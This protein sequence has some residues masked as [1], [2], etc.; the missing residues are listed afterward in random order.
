M[1]KILTPGVLFLTRLKFSWKLLFVC[2]LLT[3]PLIVALGYLWHS[4]R[5]QV[6]AT[7]TELS[8]LRYVKPVLH[9]VR[10]IQERRGRMLIDGHSSPELENQ[11]QQ[12][13]ES[14]QQN[15]S[16][17]PQA[18][19]INQEF[20]ALIEAHSALRSIKEDSPPD[21]I[22]RLHSQLV[23]SALSL[24]YRA[25]D[26]SR[27]MIDP[28][29]ETH[30]LIDLGIVHG[31]LQLENMAQLR[32]IGARALRTHTLD[33]QTLV[34]LREA[35]AAAPV[36]DRYV[37]SAFAGLTSGNAALR[38]QL[39]MAEADIATEK[40]ME[41]VS[42]Q[43][44]GAEISGSAD[45]YWKAATSAIDNVT[46]MNSKIMDKLGNAL[47][48]RIIRLRT[49]EIFQVG[50]LLLCGLFLVYFVVCF[51]KSVAEGIRQ[52]SIH[53]EYISQGQLNHAIKPV[54]SDEFSRLSQVLGEMQSS[55]VGM[56]RQ[57]RQSSDEILHSSK[58]IAS[59]AMDLSSRVEQTAA[60]LQESASSMEEI[61]STVKSTADHTEEA[62]R[63]ARHNAVVASSGGQAMHDVISTMEGIRQSSAR[64][65]EIIG[66]I[67][68]I[69]F[70]TNIL[71]LNAAVEAARAGEA[72]RGFAVV[73]TEVRMLAQR[74]A[75]AAREIK[76]LINTSVEQV[77]SGTTVVQKAG[78][79]IEEIVRSSQR[80]DQLL[81]EINTSARE[82]SL[83]VAQVGQAI[84]ELDQMTQQNAAL[85]EQ[86]A[87]AA[88]AMSDQSASLAMLMARFTL[89]EADRISPVINIF[90]DANIFDFD[91]AIEAHRQW[92]VKFRQAIANHNQ[93]DPHAICQDDQCALGKWI[94]GPGEALWGGRPLF[95]ELV[96]KHAKFH[97]S[98]GA[99]AQAINDQ[100][101]QSA[102]QLIDSGSNFARISVDVSTLLTQAKRGF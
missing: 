89:P 77:E 65:G 29:V 1:N 70:Q 11:I 5:Q 8:G 26:K 25:V 93:L 91:Q 51:Q 78:A 47:D 4:E 17:Y 84:N 7:Q 40:Y 49:D 92:K 74:S 44:L 37:E 83:G 66:A 6:L 102:E 67:D 64:I 57:I 97:A 23:Q 96:E 36:Y 56:V 33:Q 68:S 41:A 2:A 80:V 100:Q 55:L 10:L 52:V 16:I 9:Y 60:N 39:G 71:A 88:S 38:D 76:A 86:T 62:T 59:G 20:H 69:A 99:V 46:A 50:L 18:D 61:S 15:Q 45:A 12:A 35:K 42:T 34:T 79:T 28:D 24:V 85:V 14:V 75:D 73:A 53:S 19:G 43:L 82:Q 30:Y 48:A 22:F 31:P 63:V 90:G 72:G 101:Y 95:V 13:F 94:H 81:G 32:G 87:A 54:G 3:V 27:L 98:A 58:E 21:R